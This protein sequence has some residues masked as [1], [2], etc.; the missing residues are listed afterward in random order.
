MSSFLPK[1]KWNSLFW[2]SSTLVQDSEFRSFFG[3]IEETIKCFWDLLTFKTKWAK[4]G[5]GLA[6]AWPVWSWKAKKT[7]PTSNHKIA[8]SLS[9][10]T[11]RKCPSF[12]NS[13]LKLSIQRK[14]FSFFSLFGPQCFKLNVY[15]VCKYRNA[16]FFSNFDTLVSF[17]TFHLLLRFSRWQYWWK[18]E[19]LF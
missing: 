3:R 4:S 15:N 14:I 10:P 12:K 19:F 16:V 2:A 8:F 18:I 7:T 6:W 5:R 9:M 17:V 13:S 1:N 11:W